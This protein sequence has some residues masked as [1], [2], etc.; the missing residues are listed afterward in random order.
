MSTSLTHE[1]YLRFGQFGRSASW[2][3]PLIAEAEIDDE[4][5]EELIRQLRLLELHLRPQIGE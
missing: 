5:F 1:R 3:H 2:A 4:T